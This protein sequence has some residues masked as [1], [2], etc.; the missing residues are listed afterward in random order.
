MPKKKG[1]SVSHTNRHGVTYFLHRTATKKGA[2]RYV[3]KK[4]AEGALAAIPEGMEIVEDPNGLVSARRIQPQRIAPEEVALIEGHIA[5]LGLRGYRTAASGYYIT[6]YAPLQSVE[7]IEEI[8]KS[9]LR[10]SSP[11]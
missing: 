11:S 5:T 10:R 4:S 9:F 8:G 6:V 3:M 2:T 1:A 7:E